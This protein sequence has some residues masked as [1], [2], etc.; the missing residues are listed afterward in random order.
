M[1]SEVPSASP[2]YKIPG[3][4]NRISKKV[5]LYFWFE[6]FEQKFSIITFLRYVKFGASTRMVGFRKTE[7]TAPLMHAEAKLADLTK[8][9]RI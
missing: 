9:S 6:R 8:C 1:V 7:Q 4:K 3:E 5:N 2:H